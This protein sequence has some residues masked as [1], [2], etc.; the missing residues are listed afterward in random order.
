MEMYIRSDNLDRHKE[1]FKTDITKKYKEYLLTELNQ[2]ICDNVSYETTSLKEY[3]CSLDNFK[4]YFEGSYIYYDGSL[5]CFI[6]KYIFDGK[7]YKQ[8]TFEYEIRDKDIV[9]S[10][11]DYSFEEG[12]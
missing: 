1:A 11:V 3:M 5:D 6:I 12:G 8:E 2:Y 7:F 10:C 9:Y 4:I